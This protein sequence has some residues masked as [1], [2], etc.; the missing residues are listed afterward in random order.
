MVW[1][2]FYQNLLLS[3]KLIAFVKWH[4]LVICTKKNK[5]FLDPYFILQFPKVGNTIFKKK[6]YITDKRN[7]VRG[8]H[9]KTMARK[10]YLGE[11]LLTYCWRN[12]HF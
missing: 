1:I 12:F 7:V 4:F 9:V 11:Y 6:I 8:M 10:Y 2:L 5:Y 3:L